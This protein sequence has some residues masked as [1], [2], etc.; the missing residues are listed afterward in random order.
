ML[1]ILLWDRQLFE[2]YIVSF[3]VKVLQKLIIAEKTFIL[4]EKIFHQFL[5]IYKKRHTSH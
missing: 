5:L 2:Y 1:S 3:I 4:I